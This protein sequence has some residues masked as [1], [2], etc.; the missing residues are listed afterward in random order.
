[1]KTIEMLKKEHEAY[2]TLYDL[3]ADKME[4]YRIMMGWRKMDDRRADEAIRAIAEELGA[5]ADE[6]IAYYM[7]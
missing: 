6:L 5:N 4:D 1:M 2:T 7:D 3:I